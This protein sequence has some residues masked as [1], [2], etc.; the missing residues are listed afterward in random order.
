M[1]I[2]DIVKSVVA[3]V[4]PIR[5]SVSGAMRL[6]RLIFGGGGT[7]ES[8]VHTP[9]ADTPASA[10]TKTIVHRQ[11]P[12]PPIT[13]PVGDPSAVDAVSPAT[14]TERA[15]PRRSGATIMVAAPVAVGANMAAPIPAN[16]RVATA[17]GNVGDTAVAKFATMKSV[18]PARS[19]VLRGTFAA[20]AA[21]V[22]ASRA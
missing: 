4:R 11:S 5:G 18:R 1:K 9:I 2:P 7:S 19:N 17:I 16:I 10:A 22:G 15:N 12:R 3:R 21:I 14:T 6:V 13:A 8:M 20:R